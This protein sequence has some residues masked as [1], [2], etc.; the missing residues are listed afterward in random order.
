MKVFKDIFSGD[1]LLSDAFNMTVV[2]DVVFE[3]ETRYIVQGSSFAGVPEGEEGE[4]DDPS[5]EK[6]INIVAS[7]K[8]QTTSFDKKQFMSYIKM[9]IGKIVAHLE[10]NNAARVPAFKAGA[11]NFVKKVL[12]NF[13]EYTFWTG[14]SMDPEGAV[15]LSCYVGEAATPRFYFFK[16][17]LLEE[18]Y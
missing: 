6:V 11:Q 13:D 10:A 9:Y 15:A 14:E 7:S 4:L 2:D 16:D 1:E 18:K 17:G 8:L 3:I 5:E 12:G